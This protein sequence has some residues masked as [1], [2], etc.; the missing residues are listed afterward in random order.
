MRSWARFKASL[1]ILLRQTCLCRL[2]PSWPYQENGLVLDPCGSDGLRAGKVA[3]YATRVDRG[4]ASCGRSSVVERQLPKLYV[5][6][7]IPIA[8]SRF[9]G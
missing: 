5:V 1:R 8:R 3:L 4:R 7:S 6:G 9:S 2:N